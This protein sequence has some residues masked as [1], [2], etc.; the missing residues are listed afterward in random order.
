VTRTLVIGIGS[1]FEGDR[2]GWDVL[3]AMAMDRGLADE[4]GGDVEYLKLDRPGSRL[5]EYLEGADSAILI[6]ALQG[7]SMETYTRLSL[8]QLQE[9]ERLYSSHGFGVAETLRL[10]QAM[11]SLPPE[12]IIY[13]VAVQAEPDE[14]ADAIREEIIDRCSGVRGEVMSSIK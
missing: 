9:E 4:L 12:V 2:I 1:P 7:E 10:G 5:L 8:D 14:I 3:D 11:S 13:G 6:D